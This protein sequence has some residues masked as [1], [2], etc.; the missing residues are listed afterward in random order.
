M[1]QF[2]KMAQQIGRMVLPFAHDPFGIFQAQRER[3]KLELHLEMIWPDSWRVVLATIDVF[4]AASVH[5]S[6]AGDHARQMWLMGV[7]GPDELRGLY[8]HCPAA[9]D[10][11]PLNF[12]GQSPEIVLP[13]LASRLDRDAVRRATEA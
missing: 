2:S 1:Q 6:A 9:F 12:E 11:H 8:N 4:N 5:E 3:E 13:L 7:C 10:Q